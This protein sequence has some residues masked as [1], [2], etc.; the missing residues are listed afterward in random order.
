MFQ[1]D[2]RE[3]GHMQLFLIYIYIYV[4]ICIYLYID[5][6]ESDLEESASRL[7]S[8]LWQEGSGSHPS[9]RRSSKGNSGLARGWKMHVSPKQ[10]AWQ[11]VLHVN[12]A[13]SCR[14]FTILGHD[15]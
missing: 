4:Y 8:H 6:Y 14:I 12:S 1:H 10:G 9:S 13:C 7:K 11:V 15:R 2:R 5:W 3:E